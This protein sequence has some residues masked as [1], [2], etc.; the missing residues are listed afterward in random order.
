MR[1]FVIILSSIFALNSFAITEGKRGSFELANKAMTQEMVKRYSHNFKKNIEDYNNR[2]SNIGSI[3]D[4][5]N[6][7]STKK[8]FLAYVT[9]HNIKVFPKIIYRDGAAKIKLGKNLIKFSVGSLFDGY[10]LVNGKRVPLAAADFDSQEKALR[11]L[12]KRNKSFSFLSL[13]IDTAYANQGFD[14]RYE[15]T[16]IATAIIVNETFEENSWCYFCEDEYLEASQKNFD[17]VMKDVA[18]R[19]KNCKEDLDDSEK[20]TFAFNMEELA[21]YES[22]GYD[23]REKLNTYFK[24]Y[25]DSDLTCESMV[26]KLF[27]E[28]IQ[29]QKKKNKFYMNSI[30]IKEVRD[31]NK[32]VYNN[33]VVAKCQPYV[34]LRNCLIDKS[35]TGRTIYNDERKRDGK[36]RI[37][38]SR[39]LDKTYKPQSTGK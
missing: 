23:L 18:R 33:Y 26:K 15:H 3:V 22:A 32:K 38:T 8:K 21:M 7:E 25:T 31:Y 1:N 4:G 30:Q 13:I 37:R 10:M 36:K 2:R 11:A 24:S 16:M 35:Y 6:S 20:E 12:F 19:A 27:S 34:E 28:D 29:K 17:K 14:K 5:F 9:K 39:S